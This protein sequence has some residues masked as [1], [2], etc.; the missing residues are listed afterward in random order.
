[1]TATGVSGM[2][3]GTVH[4]LA[5]EDDPAQAARLC[6][7]LE[8][9]GFRVTLAASGAEALL[10]LEATVVDVIVSDVVMPGVTGY[11]LC[12]H[13]KDDPRL[14]DVPVVLLT[15]L[16][17]PLEVV[18]GLESGADSFIRKPYDADH[19]VRRLRCA[20]RNRELRRGG[21]LQ[22]G[23]RLSFLDREFDITADRQQ[24]LDLLVST[25]EELVVTSRVVRAREEELE[26]A[27][28]VT[29]RAG[30]ASPRGRAASGSTAG[31][32]P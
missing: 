6:A 1:M 18:A 16:T 28:A 4:V 12:R 9:G 7:D 30:R 25:F 5:V 31:S 27:R 26:Q 11:D 10:L 8:A 14:R 21:R 20:V 29:S 17:D 23:V 3:G 22:A 24:M 15:S 13:V 32:S 2:A 19:L